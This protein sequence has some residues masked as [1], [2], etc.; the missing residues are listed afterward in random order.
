MNKLYLYIDNNSKEMAQ[1]YISHLVD[2]DAAVIFIGEDYDSNQLRIELNHIV[3]KGYELFCVFS[4]EPVFDSGIKLQMGLAKQIAD[5]NDSPQKL[6][7][8][9]LK[10]KENNNHKVKKALIVVGVVIAVLLSAVILFLRPETEPEIVKANNLKLDE[11]YLGAFIE[12]GADSIVVDGEIS[13][14]EMLSITNL[15]LAGKGIDNLQPLLYA[16][17]LR[18]LD[19][20]NNN[21]TDITELAALS[22]LEIINLSNN[23]IDNY[24]VLDYLPNIKEVIK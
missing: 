3:A 19:L 12:A 1:R 18:Q 17:N 16:K 22:N 15:N 5:A 13:E 21:I 9:L 23:P 10:I 8:L 24:A 7:E 20:S 11:V 6:E 4:G 14:E 2:V